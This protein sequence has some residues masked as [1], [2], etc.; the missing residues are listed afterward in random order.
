MI[1]S[2][3]MGSALLGLSLAAVVLSACAGASL[4]TDFSSVSLGHSNRGR[5]RHPA[6]LPPRGTGFVVPARWRERKFQFGTDELIG[7]AQRAAGRTATG[8]PARAS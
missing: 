4:F 1:A 8:L 6:R 5:V 3:R 2:V 7:A